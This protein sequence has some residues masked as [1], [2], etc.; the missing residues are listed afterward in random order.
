MRGR[1]P[2]EPHRASTPLE[3]LFDLTFVI[4]FGVAAQQLGRLVA[5]GHVAAGL[6]GFSLA[7]FAVCWAWINFSWFASAF[8]V[9]DWIF[10]VV[11]MVQM[12]GVVVLALGLPR[13]FASI[14]HGLPLDNG[15]MVLGYVIM[16]IAMVVHWLRAAAGDPARRPACLAY[17]LAITGAQVGWVSTLLI[18]PAARRPWA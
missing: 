3:L 11:T 16:R 6:A 10:R 15:V 13:M 9:D 8:D 2:H 1:D 12:V 18:H 14:D 7:M 4:G 5:Q 17:A